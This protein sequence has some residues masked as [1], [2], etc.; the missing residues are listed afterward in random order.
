[1]AKY[2]SSSFI[3]LNI[4]SGNENKIPVLSPLKPKNQKHTQI[5]SLVLSIGYNKHK[6]VLGRYFLYSTKL[7]KKNTH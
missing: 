6:M 5:L 7:S 2:V 4:A 1:M 3:F